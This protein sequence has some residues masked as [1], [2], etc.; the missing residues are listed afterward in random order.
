MPLKRLDVDTL[1]AKIE[2]T[3]LSALM[4]AIGGTF[5]ASILYL[6]WTARRL[7]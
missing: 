2:P 7:W 3:V 5:Y 6:H 4:T 1:R